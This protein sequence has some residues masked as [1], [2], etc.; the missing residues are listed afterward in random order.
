MARSRMMVDSALIGLG[1]LVFLLG[2]QITP[3]VSQ[4]A[5]PSRLSADEVFQA[6]LRAGAQNGYAITTQ[7]R[8][9]GVATMEKTVGKLRMIMSVFVQ[10]PGDRVQVATNVHAGGGIPIAGLYEETTRNFYT[11]LFR[12]L[13]ISDPADRQIEI[14][15]A[16]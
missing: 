8:T 4:W 2:C 5:A 16:R 14:R 3:R 10:K 15:E 9:S 7:D 1:G 6:S 12:E 13:L 11:Y